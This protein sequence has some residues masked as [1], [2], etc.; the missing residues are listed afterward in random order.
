MVFHLE[1]LWVA[2]LAPGA[3]GQQSEVR[4]N[5]VWELELMWGRSR[6]P[7]RRKPQS[8]LQPAPFRPFP[9]GSRLTAEPHPEGMWMHAT[10]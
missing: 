1:V 2:G 6:A 3:P 9:G 4:M 5:V 8:V 10:R 7:S